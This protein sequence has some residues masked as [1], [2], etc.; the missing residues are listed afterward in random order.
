[1]ERD[2]SQLFQRKLDIWKL[3]ED[4]SIGHALVVQQQSDAPYNGR[5]AYVLGAG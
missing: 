2:G 5:E 4:G 1:L 3:E